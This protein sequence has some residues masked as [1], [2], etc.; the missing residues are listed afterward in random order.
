MNHNGSKLWV[1]VG[2][3]VVPNDNYGDAKGSEN[4]IAKTLFISIFITS[5]P[6]L[7]NHSNGFLVGEVCKSRFRPRVG[8]HG[9]H[10]HCFNY[11]GAP[12]S[13]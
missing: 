4:R 13:F 5:F 6:M 11:F 9:C 12:L 3:A 1:M 2:P 10:G 8:Y 7:M